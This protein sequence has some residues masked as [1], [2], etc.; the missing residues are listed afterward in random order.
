MHASSS[1]PSSF[2]N[3]CHAWPSACRL[4]QD[5]LAA[6][7]FPCGPRFAPLAGWILAHCLP[8]VC[9][10]PKLS[11]F[12]HPLLQGGC[13]S[14]CICIPDGPF[15]TRP[16]PMRGD[17]FGLVPWLPL[18]WRGATHPASPWP[19]ERISMATPGLHRSNCMQLPVR[20]GQAA[21]PSPGSLYSVCSLGGHLARAL[22]SPK[23]TP[24]ARRVPPKTKELMQELVQ[25][26]SP[27]G[28]EPAAPSQ[29]STKGSRR[30]TCR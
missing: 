8:L 5:A 12:C 28:L 17:L 13:P 7:C 16:A 18:P 19:G 29:R 4:C 20:I 3:A 22:V 9:P 27:L 24:T 1:S 2:D 11:T 15:C 10:S 6:L 23:I 26:L 25:V 30:L 14:T 21:C